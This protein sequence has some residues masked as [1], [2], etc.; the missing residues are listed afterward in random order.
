MHQIASVHHRDSIQY[1]TS[2]LAALFLL[3]ISSTPSIPLP[4]LDH[5]GY[6]W[7]FMLGSLNQPTLLN[8]MHQI[9]SVHHRD[10]IK[11]YTSVPAVLVLLLLSSTP[12]TPAVTQHSGMYIWIFIHESLKQQTPLDFVHYTVF[13]NHRLSSDSKKSSC[14]ALVLLLLPSVASILPATA[15]NSHA[16]SWFFTLCFWHAQA[17]STPGSTSQQHIITIHITFSSR[18]HPLPLAST[19]Y[20]PAYSPVLKNALNHMHYQHSQRNLL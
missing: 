8:S 19:G 9:V 13:I 14:T 12:S 5:Q 4:L 17:N 15:R 18:E 10:S 16:P 1:Y 7:I 2:V 3:V 11:Y 20:N 6:I